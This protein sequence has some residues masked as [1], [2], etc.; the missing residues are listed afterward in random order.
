MPT[1]LV[2]LALAALGWGVYKLFSSN[3]TTKDTT[4]TTKEN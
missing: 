3:T 4:E 1:L 2:V